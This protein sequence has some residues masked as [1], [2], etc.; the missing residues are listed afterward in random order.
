MKKLEVLEF[1]KS[2]P[3][4]ENVLK[5]EPYCLNVSRAEWNG[6]RLVMLKYS[7][8]NSSFAERMVRE[9]RGLIFDE[10]TLKPV[11]VPFFKFMNFGEPNADEIDWSKSPYVLEKKDG[12]LIKIVKYDGRILISTNGLILASE[13]RLAPQPGCVYST[14]EDLVWWALERRLGP[15]PRRKIS[16]LIPEGRTYMFELCTPFNR[17][18]IP[19]AESEIW[20]IGVRDNDTM[21]ETFIL[22][23]PLSKVFKIPKLYGFSTFETCIKTARELPWTAEGYVVTSR[24]FK[25]VKVKS[26]AYLSCHA[27]AGNGIMTYERAISLMRLNETSEVTAYF[28]NF[29][30]V[31]YEIERRISLF[32]HELDVE[33]RGFTEQGMLNADRRAQAMWIKKNFIHTGAAFAMLNGKI[34]GFRE[35]FDSLPDSVAADIVKS[36]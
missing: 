5:A 15:D 10:D 17:V 2:R 27:L 34:A 7:Q 19:S 11:S 25:R 13:A 20:F 28:P 32:L 8:F 36:I 16:D 24:D 18:V 1:I 9:S 33:W 26:L 23:D 3:D 35:W 21:E 29:K 22:D 14:Y 30:E 31:F 12:S 4:W 6:H